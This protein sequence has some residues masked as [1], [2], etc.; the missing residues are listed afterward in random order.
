MRPLNKYDT[1]YKRD[2]RFRQFKIHKASIL[3]K[4]SLASILLSYIHIFYSILKWVGSLIGVI[5][6]WHISNFH[7]CYQHDLAQIY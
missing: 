6:F 4:N 1:L 5:I 2:K 7:F 3:F